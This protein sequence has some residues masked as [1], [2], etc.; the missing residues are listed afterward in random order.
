VEARER[1]AR[2]TCNGCHGSPLETNTSV[3]Q[4]SPRQQGVTSQRSP[5]L[6]GTQVDD[7]FANALR[8]FNELSRRE[9]ILHDLV[10]PNDP[11]PPPPPDEIPLGGGDGGAGFGGG[12]GG[13]GDGGFGTGGAD[14]GFGFGS[15]DG[16]FGTGSADANG[17]AGAGGT[18][19]RSPL[20]VP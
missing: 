11:L 15:A 14:G 9:R 20:P 7:P 19:A 18:D 10:C 5:F 1:F 6:V 13:F 4:L 17:S 8:N 12:D 3:F 16:G 2:N